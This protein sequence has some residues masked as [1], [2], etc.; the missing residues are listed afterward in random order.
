L[1]CFRLIAAA[2]GANYGYVVDNYKRI[3][4]LA[5]SKDD[6]ASVDRAWIDCLVAAGLLDQAL[7]E[8]EMLVAVNP[9]SWAAIN[10]T[11]G[12]IHSRLGDL[13][14]AIAVQK[15]ILEEDPSFTAA[16]WN[17]SIHQLEAGHLPEA[18]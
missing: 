10:S 4:A 18:F 5:P 17:L 13:D 11:I 8:A 14:K 2:K 6:Q 15:S 9:G 3:R 12:V 7:R 16:R 1:W